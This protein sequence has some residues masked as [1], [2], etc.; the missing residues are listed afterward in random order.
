MRREPV[1]KRK[2]RKRLDNQR[3]SNIILWLTCVT[4]LTA[5]AGML[6]LGVSQKIISS[7]YNDIVKTDLAKKEC[8]SRISEGLYHHQALIFQYII[9][10]DRSEDGYNLKEESEDVR[11]G[12]LSNL[13]K[14]GEM[15]L[16][17]EYESYY[18]GIYSELKGYFTNIDNVLYFIENG[19]EET[20]YYYMN[21]SLNSYISK[22]NSRIEEFEKLISEDM[23]ELDRQM[24]RRT[25]RSERGI[26]LILAQVIILSVFSMVTCSKISN[27]IISEDALTCVNNYEKMQKYCAKLAAQGK[28]SDYS[29][30]FCNIRDFKMFNNT[31]GDKAGDH[32]LVEYASQID[33]FLKRDERIARNGGDNFIVIVQ[34][35]RVSLFLSYI[36]QIEVTVAHGGEQNIVP[37]ESY[38]GICDIQ[39]EDTPGAVFSSCNLALKTARAGG[40]SNVVWYERKMYDD[41]K[42][43]KEILTQC[44]KGMRKNEFVVFYQPKV[45]MSDN[46]LCG[47]EALVRWK[48]NEELIPPYRFIPV[49][50]EE[51]MIVELDFYVF[52]RVCRD[53]KEWLDKG[54]TP[55][56]VSVNFS[57]LHLKDS[58]FADKILAVIETYSVDTRYI[59]IELTESSAYDDFPAL[60][61]FVDKMKKNSI[62]TSMD[63]FG[64]GY[65]S[66]SML[67][68]LNVDVIKIDK[69][70][71]DDIEK[72]DITHEKMI[73]NVVHM[74]LDLNREV[75]CE[76]VETSG[77]ADFLKS[78][79]CSV[80]QG[81]LYDKPLDHDEFERRLI[82]PEYDIR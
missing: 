43:R 27:Q 60:K 73:E 32:I 64:T 51:G 22:V 42:N 44:Q 55:V 41:M 66:L 35:E 45:N 4:M 31:F 6:Y 40:N 19:D 5:I 53:I 62:F 7:K 24:D 18:Y 37:V 52:E 8:M 61:E 46:I 20:A 75:I 47:C 39:R 54:I 82:N 56:R 70:F 2:R 21:S 13:D 72:G 3:R 15:V 71:I 25:Y 49:L 17:Q 57:K 65:S 10:G 68:D 77:Q 79:Q 34:S 69:S 58:S 76:G 59:E 12:V 9:S 38:C 81:Y 23:A 36:K 26:V 48:H 30:V 14:F 11:D 16:G 78:I 50:E 33:M 63:D 29:C 80:A 67:K 28:F 1:K 74:I